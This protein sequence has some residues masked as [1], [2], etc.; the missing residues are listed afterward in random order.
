MEQET[1]IQESFSY[2]EEFYPIRCVTC[3]YLLSKKEEDFKNLL[4]K[5]FTK[6]EALNK[7]NV[8]HTCCRMAMKYPQKISMAPRLPNEP[9]YRFISETIKKKSQSEEAQK[10]VSIREKTR[11]RARLARESKLNKD[12]R[13]EE[14]RTFMK[15][16]QDDQLIPT[17]EVIK[18]FRAV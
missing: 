15:P 11:E 16:K 9:T 2:I 6:D 8:E 7:L 5:G 18:K 12:Q 13:L 1:P 10:A 4:N 17:S 14:L 3:G